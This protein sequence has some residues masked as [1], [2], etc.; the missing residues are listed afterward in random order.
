MGV[1][2]ACLHMGETTEGQDKGCAR[3]TDLPLQI[4]EGMMP[5]VNAINIVRQKKEVMRICALHV[6]LREENTSSD[7]QRTDHQE[8]ELVFCVLWGGGDSELSTQ[9][10]RSGRQIKQIAM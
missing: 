3:F 7:T 4:N 5:T 9:L 1:S 6:H 2:D 8:C 10:N